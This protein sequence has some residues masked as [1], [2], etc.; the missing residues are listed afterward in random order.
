M[1]VPGN[2]IVRSVWFYSWRSGLYGPYSYGPYSYG[3]Y[4]Y[5][6]RYWLYS[7]RSGLY[8]PYSHGPYRYGKKVLVVF[9]ALWWVIGACV[10]TFGT[11]GGHGGWGGKH[12]WPCAN[13]HNTASQFNVGRSNHHHHGHHP[14]RHHR[15]GGHN[16]HRH[17]RHSGSN[18]NACMH[19]RRHT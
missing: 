17:H 14:H 9:L 10:L 2:I 18:G 12:A 7:W 13:T 4:S 6:K 5:G 8:G 1:K 15:H 16:P 3:P 19:T 11:S